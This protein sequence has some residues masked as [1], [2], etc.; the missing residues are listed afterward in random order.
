MRWHERGEEAAEAREVV[1]QALAMVAVERQVAA[2]GGEAADWLEA[3]TA[4]AAAAEIVPVGPARVQHW[5][6]E[7]ECTREAGEADAALASFQRLVEAVPLGGPGEGFAVAAMCSTAIELT[8]LEFL[9]RLVAQVPPPRAHSV[10]YGGVLA[11][12]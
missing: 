10:L 7:A 5:L 8:R 2:E 3:A 12:G 9:E 1:A 4:H 6:A 11:G